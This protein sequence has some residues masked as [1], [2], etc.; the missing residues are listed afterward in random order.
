MV[1]LVGSFCLALV[2]LVAFAGCGPAG[3]SAISASHQDGSQQ[4]PPNESLD[5]LVKGRALLTLDLAAGAF[6]P[7]ATS[8]TI[9]VQIVNDASTTFTLDVSRFA[10]PRAANAVLDFGSVAVGGLFDNDLRR[11]GTNGNAKCTKAFLRMFTTGVAGAGLYN[12]AGGY[13]MP[14]TAGLSGATAQTVG[15]EVAN[16]VVLQT[17]TI[18]AN[19]NVL[20]LLDFAPVPA[21]LIKSDFSDAGAGSY[22]TTLVLEYGLLP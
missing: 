20:R 16:S 8:G 6:S 5:G 11:C 21:F 1:R 12:A 14:I 7:L 13:G 22:S 9:P 3:T 17:I 18:A 10:I 19:K 15:L 4:A 2:G